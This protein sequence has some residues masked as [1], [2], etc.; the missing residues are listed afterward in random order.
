M[1][2]RVIWAVP[3]ERNISEDAFRGFLNVA[4][5]AAL[6]GYVR[7]DAPYQRVDVSRNNIVRAFLR[8]TTHDDDTLVMLDADHIHPANVI[9]RLVN[10]N[11]GVVGALAFKRGAPY[12]PCFFFRGSDKKLHHPIEWDCSI[13]L[14]PCAIVGTG[15]IAIQRWVFGALD[16]A[17]Y[18]WPYFLCT[19]PD[20]DP[21]DL[22]K[23][24][25]PSED[26][27]FGL[28]C[29]DAGIPH[30]VDVT[31]D[32]PHLMTSISDRVLWEQYKAEHPVKELITP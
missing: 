25:H 1:S 9:E 17:G 29:E 3:P 31:F 2:K 14:L 22:E 21:N 24:T 28:A 6:R 4:Q 30:H 5:Q 23:Y 13:K 19:Y 12:D 20:P 15:A 32:T 26:M 8:E 18:Q 27:A 16:K 7:M 10:W 11:V